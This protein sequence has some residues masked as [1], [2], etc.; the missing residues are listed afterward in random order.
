MGC[1]S[2]GTE[3]VYYV[4]KVFDAV[5]R[6]VKALR[7]EYF[8]LKP[9]PQPGFCSPSPTYLPNSPLLGSLKYGERFMYEGRHRDSY[10]RSLFL[11]EYQGPR[12]GCS[13]QV[14]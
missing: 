7:R 5:A 6:A 12:Q 2:F 9:Q 1:D 11:A 8:F 3:Q 13:R 14:L 4:P 10:R